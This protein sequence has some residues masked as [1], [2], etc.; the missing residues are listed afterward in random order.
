MKLKGKATAMPNRPQAST[1][2]SF[3]PN[4]TQPVSKHATS[5][6]APT[7][8]TVTPI[9]GGPTQA[10]TDKKEQEGEGKRC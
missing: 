4:K 6:D 3:W 10:T 2:F 8:D 7:V 5:A 9:N 1:L